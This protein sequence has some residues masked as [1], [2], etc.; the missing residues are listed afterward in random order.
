MKITE[1]IKEAQVEGKFGPQT[2]TAF[3]VEGD[4]RTLSAFTKF[5]LKVGQE[6]DGEITTTEKDGRTYYNFKFGSKS[7]SGTPS[8]DLNRVEMKLD[9]L[10]AGQR[11]LGGEITAIKSVLGEILSK[12]APVD[13]SPF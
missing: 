11:T 6:I 5:P 9:A 1:I 10:I 12:V 13:T 2:R 7:T 4:E 8:G 3:K